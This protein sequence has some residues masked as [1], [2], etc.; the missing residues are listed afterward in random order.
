MLRASYGEAFSIARRLAGLITVPGLLP[1]AGPVGM[2]SRTLMTLALRLM[3][4]LILPEDADVVARLWRGAGRISSLLD[5][6]PPFSAGQ[7][8]WR[9]AG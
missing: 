4:N 7:R 2:R 5:P 8:T 6:R 3:G 9:T 1:A